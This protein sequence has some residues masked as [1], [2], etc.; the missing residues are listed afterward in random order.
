MKTNIVNCTL[1]K[2]VVLHY[3]KKNKRKEQLFEKVD[4]PNLI[5]ERITVKLFQIPCY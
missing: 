3:R 5:P 4:K 2:V 1:S